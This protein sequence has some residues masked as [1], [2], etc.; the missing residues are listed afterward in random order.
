MQQLV[1]SLKYLTLWGRISP[2]PPA[3]DKIG[4]GAVYFP[5][6]G[7][8]LGL[9]LALSN[10]VLLPYLPPE[11]LSVLL[12]TILIVATGGNHLQGVGETFGAPAPGNAPGPA[13]SSATFG[14]VVA[15]LVIIF[16]IAAT[17]SMDE[18]LTLSLLLAPLLARWALVVFIYEYQDRCEEWPRRIAQNVRSWHL[19][20]A[21]LGS[22]AIAVYFLGR[23]GLWIALLLSLFTLSL[24]ALFYRKQSVLTHDHL[25]AAVE[26]AEALCFVLLAS[27]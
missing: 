14:V 3:P 2:F 9:V 6:V 8:A 20:L 18:K 7:L 12:V 13:Q 21:T 15:V 26:F 16:K 25:G 27:I 1:N 11:L 24:R 19:I 22:L 17:H 10:Y 5:L 23:K 4:A